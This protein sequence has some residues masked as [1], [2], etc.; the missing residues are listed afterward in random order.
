MAAQRLRIRLVEVP[1]GADRDVARAVQEAAAQS[2]FVLAH[3]DPGVFS[4][5]TIQSI[6]LTTYRARV[7]L[8]GFSPAYT[9]AGA[10]LSLHTGSGQLAE[11]AA[12]MARQFWQAGALPAAQ[13]PR[14][15]EVS[16]NRQVARSLGVEVPAESV[17]VERLRQKERGQ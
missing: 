6:L 16:V 5:Q 8:F 1:V 12:E 3:P 11:Q 14:D 17:L 15:Y 13:Y 4:P 10:L 7:P 2:E 9:R